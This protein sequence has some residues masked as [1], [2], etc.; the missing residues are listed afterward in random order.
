[1]RIN[2]ILKNFF[3]EIL[4]T[5]A[6]STVIL[7]VFILYGNL[8]KHD[9]YFLQALSI[10][11]DVFVKL[12]LYLM[13]YALSFALPFG[14]SLSLLLCYG[15]WSSTNQILALRSLGIS[16]FKVGFTGYFFVY[17]NICDFNFRFLAVWSNKSS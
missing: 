2:C 9:E 7:L 6:L 17:F 16:I 15:K 4:I 12:L 11:P 1:M 8:V 10:A 5:T 14:F 13:P 3:F